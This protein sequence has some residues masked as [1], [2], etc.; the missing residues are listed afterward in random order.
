MQPNDKGQYPDTYLNIGGGKWSKGVA[1]INGFNLVSLSPD[2]SLV[3]AAGHASRY[4]SRSCNSASA[5]VTHA[6]VL[7]SH[8]SSCPVKEVLLRKVSHTLDS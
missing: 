1:F 7:G 8:S 3:F 2:H 6:E 5:G 4:L